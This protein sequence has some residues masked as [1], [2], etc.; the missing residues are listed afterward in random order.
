M[1]PIIKIRKNNR[2]GQDEE[3]HN[4]T[5]MTV[6]HILNLLKFCLKN[7][8]Y[9]SKGRLYKQIEGTAINPLVANIYMEDFEV[10]SMKTSDNSPG[11]GE[12]M[13]VILFSL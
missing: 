1:D 2:L 8:H 12:D 3:L 9:L 10:K 7:T 4:R 6:G 11:C 5:Y 13:Q